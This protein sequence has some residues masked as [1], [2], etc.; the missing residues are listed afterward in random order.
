MLSLSTT[1]RTLGHRYVAVN[2]HQCHWTDT[3]EPLKS[4]IDAID[5]D[6]M[7][8]R[9]FRHQKRPKETK[10]HFLAE[11]AVLTG[12]PRLS[13]VLITELLA[14]IGFKLLNSVFENS[15]NIFEL[16]SVRR[17]S[18]PLY[19]EVFYTVYSVLEKHFYSK[20]CSLYTKHAINSLLFYIQ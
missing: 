17:I 11:H 10:S 18:A 13:P 15:A 1:L 9:P 2:W 12:K 19:V 3:G 16:F 20:C 5:T 6:L 14:S 8:T 4:V 7:I